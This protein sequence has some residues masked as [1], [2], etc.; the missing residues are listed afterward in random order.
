MVTKWCYIRVLFKI[1]CVLLIM[2]LCFGCGD[3]DTQ[4]LTTN[5]IVDNNDEIVSQYED[6]DEN[7]LAAEE[8]V[9]VTMNQELT[10][11]INHRDRD[12]AVVTSYW[13]ESGSVLMA[14]NFFGKL[15]TS[16]SRQKIRTTWRAIFAKRAQW[17]MN[18]T[19]DTIWIDGKGRQARS[20]GTFAYM[21]QAVRPFKAL[22][23]KNKQDIWKVKAIDYGD[24]GFIKGFKIIL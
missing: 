3:E 13:I 5:T 23:Q 15:N 4:T 12:P 6:L 19:I 16:K 1:S 17:P 24:N 11:A 10:D 14:H 2:F 7:A 8:L 20:V 21:G 18:S 22:Y 9:I